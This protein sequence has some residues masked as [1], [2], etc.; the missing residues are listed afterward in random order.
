ME[1]EGSFKP[2]RIAA[3]QA[4]N[5]SNINIKTLDTDSNGLTVVLKYSLV[6]SQMTEENTL[7]VGLF[8]FLP[9]L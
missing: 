9:H 4:L 1:G 2:L 7:V 6:H 5:R 8:F 3:V